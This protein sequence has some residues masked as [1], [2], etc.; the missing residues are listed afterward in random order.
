MRSVGRLSVNW[1]MD[2][3][4]K[5]G[6]GIAALLMAIMGM[7]VILDIARPKA[8]DSVLESQAKPE[9]MEETKVSEPPP[10]ESS[11]FSSDECQQGFYL[12]F[13]E[14][15]KTACASNPASNPTIF[16][17]P[18]ASW[19]EKANGIP[20]LRMGDVLD[21]KPLCRCLDGL[22][23]FSRQE[24]DPL[25]PPVSEVRYAGKLRPIDKWVCGD[26]CIHEEAGR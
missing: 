10:S 20:I 13:S 16:G 5:A 15:D 12:L 21:N 11:I 23:A 19:F 17:P 6:L 26:Q 22:P 8:A 9:S 3:S 18:D 7:E 4:M 25:P 1:S 24:D 2:L 14:G